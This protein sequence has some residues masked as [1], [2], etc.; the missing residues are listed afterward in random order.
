MLIRAHGY[1]R[2]MIECR[3]GVQNHTAIPDFDHNYCINTYHYVYDYCHEN[4]HL[5]VVQS[6]LPFVEFIRCSL[7]MLDNFVLRFAIN[8]FR[9]YK[10]A[11]QHNP[12][13]E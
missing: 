8:L 10:N 6:R 5:R 3:R 13:D 11:R 7:C 4:V 9:Y 12:S 1:W 2:T